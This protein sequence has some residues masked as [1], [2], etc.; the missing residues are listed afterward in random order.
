[1]KISQIIYQVIK[2][3]LKQKLW[4]GEAYGSEA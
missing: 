3:T 2:G 4:L 1:M